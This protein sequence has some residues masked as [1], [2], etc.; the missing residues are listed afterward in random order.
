[1]NKIRLYILFFLSPVL[2]TGCLRQIDLEQIKSENLLVVDAMITDQPVKQHITLSRTVALNNTT[3]FSPET[4]AIVRLEGENSS[5]IHFQEVTAG[6]YETSF[7]FAAQLNVNYQLHIVTQNGREYQSKLAS[8]TPTPPLDSVYVEFESTPSPTNPFGGYFN[9]YV[10]SRTNPEQ[11]KYYRWIWNSTYELTVPNPSRWLWTGG[12]NFILRELGSANDSLQVE[13]CWDTDTTKE[14][15]IKELLGGEKDIVRHPISRFHSDSGYM[16][17]RYSIEVKQYALSEESYRF[18][19]LVKESTNQGL[20]F[21]TQVGSIRGNIA[22]ITN[23][24]ELVLGFFEV[25]QE[26]SERKFYTPSDFHDQGFR[27]LDRHIIDCSGDEPVTSRID[28]IGAFMQE[29]EYEYTL[30]YFITTPPSAAF[31]RIRCADCTYY[32]GSN[33]K[34]DF[35]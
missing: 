27:V 13:V 18:W 24:N 25:V 26:Q 11:N 2:L 28:E 23:D 30:C 7:P 17:I 1:M 5:S 35:W 22:N 14:I 19:N 6:H 16:K 31:C 15:N 12:N 3:P 20:L 4:G 34:P 33:K 32:A 10:D 9:F 21:D 29:H 8:I